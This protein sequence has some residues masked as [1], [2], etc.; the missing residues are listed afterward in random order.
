[1][2]R[3]NNILS[4]INNKECSENL[5][6]KSIE[7]AKSNQAKLTFVAIVP[8]VS[9]GMEIRPRDSGS[10]DLQ[11]KLIKDRLEELN[12]ILSS[13]SNHYNFDVKVLVGDHS[14]EIIKNILINNHDLLISLPFKKR[15][16][17]SLFTSKDMHLFRKCP[18]PV[19]FVGHEKNTRFKKI[20]AAVDFDRLEQTHNDTLSND[21]VSIASEIALLNM[22]ELHIVNIYNNRFSAIASTWAEQPD[23]VEQEIKEYALDYANR[24]MSYLIESLKNNIGEDMYKQISIQSHLIFGD[25]EE[26]LPLF[27]SRIQS[28]LIVMGTVARTGISG[29][30]IGNTAEDILCQLKCSV[31]TIKPKGFI[32]PITID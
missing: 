28:D 18:C 23:K 17:E 9:T 8:L 32:S 31:L 4:V 24:K 22:A 20:I 6:S 19:F 11:K 12:E 30:L 27:S 5:I 10:E 29:L 25:A 7:I 2:S 26:Q 21:I 3:F 1:M 14:I 16:L 15:I 13:F